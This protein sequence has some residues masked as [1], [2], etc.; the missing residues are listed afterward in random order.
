MASPTKIV[1]VRR[2]LRRAA[3]G[4]RRKNN[5]RN[6]GTT[7]KDLPLDKPNANEKKAAPKATKGAKA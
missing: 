1:K 6:H 4:K 2:K 5:A 7:K 3:A